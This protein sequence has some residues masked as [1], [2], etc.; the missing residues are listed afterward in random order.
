MPSPVHHVWYPMTVP[1]SVCYFCIS[2]RRAYRGVSSNKACSPKA[3][4]SPQEECQHPYTFLFIKKET[5]ALKQHHSQCGLWLVWDLVFPVVTW[6]SI[7]KLLEK[8][9][10][11]ISWLRNLIRKWVYNLYLHLFFHFVILI[12]HEEFEIIKKNLSFTA[13]SLRSTV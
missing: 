3:E 10:K 8:F 12:M 13:T 5:K 9:D 4:C 2:N 6:V 1:P 7:Q 11:V